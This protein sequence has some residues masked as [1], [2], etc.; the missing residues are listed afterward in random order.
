[1]LSCQTTRILAQSEQV[2]L[3]TRWGFVLKELLLYRL[4]IQG[5]TF[6]IGGMGR[7]HLGLTCLYLGTVSGMGFRKDKTF[8]KY[9]FHLDGGMNS[10]SMSH[11]HS[12]W[13][14]CKTNSNKS[15][16]PSGPFSNTLLIN[17]WN[18]SSSKTYPSG[19][20]EGLLKQVVL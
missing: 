19:S 20:Q 3:Q 13:V 16:G 6:S 5:W 9:S 12:L 15:S 14:K 8:I 10:C 4:W 17:L 7:H 18:I 1:M 11:R 2:I